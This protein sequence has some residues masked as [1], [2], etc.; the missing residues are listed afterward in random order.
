M[1]KI[2]FAFTAF[3]AILAG[4]SKEAETLTNDNED[5]VAGRSV[6]LR[7]S[8]PENDTKVSSDNGGTFKWQAGDKITVLNTDGDPFDFSAQAGGTAVDFSSATFDGTLSTNAFYPANDNHEAGSYYL[9]PSFAW[10]ANSSSMPMIGTVDTVNETATFSSVGG[11]LKL[12]LFNVPAAAR[13][14]E[15]SSASNNLTGLFTVSGD[16]KKIVTAAG[17]NKKVTITFGAG[18]DTN[19]AF[20]IPLPTGELGALTFTLSDGSSTLFTKTTKGSVSLSRNQLLVAPVLNCGT[21]ED[22]LLSNDD[23]KSHFPDSYSAAGTETINGLTWG[24]FDVAHYTSD[25]L[26]FRK[27]TG[28]LKVPEFTSNIASVVVYGVYNGSKGAFPS[29]SAIKFFADPD[30][31]DPLDSKAGNDTAGADYTL[32]VPE[33]NTTGYIMCSGSAMQITSVRITF[34]P[35][36]YSAPTITPADDPV[37][38]AVASGDTNSGS[39]S[40]TYSNALASDDL[41]LSIVS[42]SDWITPTLTGS[43]TSYTLSVSASKRIIAGDREGTV[44]IRGTGVSK[45]INVS[46][47][48]AFVPNPSVNVVPGNGTFTATWSEAD[49]SAGYVAYLGDPNNGGTNITSDIAYN[50]GAHTYTL[51]KSVANDDYDL[52]VGVTAAANYVAESGYTV[53]SFTCSASSFAVNITQPG[54]GGSFTANGNSV[55]FSASASDVITLVAS[56]STG[57]KLASWSVT[58][59]ASGDAVSVSD[60][61]FIMPAEAVDVTATFAAKKWVMVESASS[62]SAG[63]KLIIVAQTATVT[64]AANGTISKSVMGYVDASISG[65][66]LTSYTGAQEFTLGGTSGSWT[67]SNGSALLGSSAAKSVAWDSGTTIW[68]IAI[69]GETHKATITNG[70]S[71]NGWFQY[72]A[73]SPRFTTYTSSQ[74]L[75]YLFRY[76]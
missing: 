12:I 67:L 47:P 2:L 29:S 20:Y 73:S 5:P 51:T 39:T 25:G 14:L 18:H 61:S 26:Q 49:N 58:K 68:T 19:M 42:H 30:D 23:I 59:T 21:Y 7:A 40:V 65:S 66:E 35:A 76:E 16:P 54:T 38:I 27:A 69:D 32:S 41:G 11:V 9:A 45:T 62:L 3:T 22:V 64:T 15:V 55:S 75:P 17:S 72:N 31:D 57:Y 70:T 56:P 10:V 36:A 71:A 63:D 53:E 37:V 74:T 48:T 44:V 50:S 46:Q 24:H 8:V 13:Q 60:N 34:R 1:K 4:C 28:Y 43:G 52:Y 33:G 6:T